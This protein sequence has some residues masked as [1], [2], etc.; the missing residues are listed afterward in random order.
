[1]FS[2]IHSHK[3]H[4]LALLGFL[5]RERHI[6]LP[7]DIP[8]TYLVKSSGALRD[9]TKK[10]HHS[11][12]ICC[13]DRGFT[14]YGGSSDWFNCTF[15]SW[16]VSPIMH[17]KTGSQQNSCLL[18]VK[19]IL[20]YNGVHFSLLKT[21]VAFPVAQLATAKWPI[22]QESTCCLQPRLLLEANCICGLWQNGS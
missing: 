11:M 20:K 12:H 8:L 1:M 17:K 16:H 14:P 15:I 2:R 5:Q 3:I 4:H 13:F 7:F 6:S 9:D 10:L 22:L 21:L 18:I 19:D